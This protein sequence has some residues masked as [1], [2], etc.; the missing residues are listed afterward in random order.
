MGCDCARQQISLR[1]SWTLLGARNELIWPNTVLV[2]L[3][4]PNP[5][6]LTQFSVFSVSRRNC[7]FNL[8]LSRR[9][10]KFFISDASMLKKPG[11]R[12][13]PRPA[14]PG[15]TAPCGTGTKQAVLNQVRPCVLD[16]AEPAYWPGWLA[17]GS[18]IMSG[19]G[20]DELDPR[21]PEP[22]GSTLEVVTVVGAP[23]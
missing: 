22:A 19:R 6:G 12:M 3:V 17:R 16:C 11:V 15:R 1:A 9:S 2:M 7:A 21:K 14:L 10:R 5:L 13:T 20:P 23:V 8:S 4:L 18:Q